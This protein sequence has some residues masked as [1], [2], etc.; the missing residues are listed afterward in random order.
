VLRDLLQDGAKPAKN[1][2]DEMRSAGF[3]DYQTR[4]ARERLGIRPRKEGFGDQARWVWEL[5]AEDGKAPKDADKNES[6]HLKRT[7]TDK[8][9][10]GNNL[11][12][13]VKGDF[14]THLCASPSQLRGETANGDERFRPEFDDPER[15]REWDAYQ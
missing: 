1:A 2:Q 3:N 7:H 4:S 11:D 14:S 12:E 5:P 6:S 15:Q 9:T 10:Y 13:D 8:S